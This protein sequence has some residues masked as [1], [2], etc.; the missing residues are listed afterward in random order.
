M[1]EENQVEGTFSVRISIESRDL[2]FKNNV[3]LIGNEKQRNLNSE[4]K[5][6]EMRERRHVEKERDIKEIEFIRGNRIKRTCICVNYD[7]GLFGLF[8]V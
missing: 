6:E 5:E 1:I 7:Y 2:L 4:F 3:L 8:V